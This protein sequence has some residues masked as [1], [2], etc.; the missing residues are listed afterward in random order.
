VKCSLEVVD[1]DICT[2]ITKSCF[3]EKVLGYYL[4]CFDVLHVILVLTF[5]VLEVDICFI[6][7]FRRGYYMIICLCTAE[8]KTFTKVPLFWCLFIYNHY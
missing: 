2:Y 4:S 3:R 7:F 6:L 5:W 8:K 1:F